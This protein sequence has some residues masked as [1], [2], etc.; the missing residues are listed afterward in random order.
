MPK[1]TPG[2]QRT[3]ERVMH[4]FKHGEL[5]QPGGRKVKSRKQAV[6]IALREAGDSKFES[7]AE[8][9]RALKHTKAKE[10]KAETGMDE[11]EGKG[12]SRRITKAKAPKR[13]AK[14]K[15]AAKRKG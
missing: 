4:E 10:R 7:R 8:N 9:K 1:E 2:Q 11:Q 6:A 13:P 12:A 3:V 5:K 14:K 15:R